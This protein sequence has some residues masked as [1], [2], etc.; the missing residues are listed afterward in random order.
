LS[1]NNIALGISASITGIPVT[2]ATIL[3]FICSVVLFEVGYAIGNSYLSNIFG[4]YT[5]LISGILLI[6]LGVYELFI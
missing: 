3:T 6:I 1:L 5:P 4:K 2:L